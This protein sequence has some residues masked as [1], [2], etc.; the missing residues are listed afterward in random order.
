[1]GKT[2]KKPSHKATAIIICKNCGNEVFNNFCNRC[3]GS[4]GWSWCKFRTSL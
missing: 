4:K 1:M 2:L 3:G